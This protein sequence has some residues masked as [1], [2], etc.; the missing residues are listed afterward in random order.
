MFDKL[1]LGGFFM[2][3]TRTETSNGI[4]PL[5]PQNV[6]AN[7]TVKSAEVKEITDS[8]SES[9]ETSKFKDIVSK[10]D[11]TNMSRTEAD[12]MFRTL[13]DNNLIDLKSLMTATFD[14]THVPGWQDGVSSVN[15]WKV[16]GNS[17]EKMNY[18][19]GFKIQ[20]E[21]NKKFGNPEFQ[22][23]YDKML[24]LFEKI[25]YLQS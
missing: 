23:Q 4:N 10:Y 9:D 19:E 3:I 11:V 1:N 22:H 25:E 6:A 21:Y 8:Y 12:K 2:N 20:A 13:Y 14:P 18:L 17:D 24:E 7:N 16:S 5:Y 15:G